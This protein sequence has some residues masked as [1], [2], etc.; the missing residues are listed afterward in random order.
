MTNQAGAVDADND[1]RF[2]IAVAWQMALVAVKLAVADAGQRC[3]VDMPENDGSS[4][5][6]QGGQGAPAKQ[7]AQGREDA[8]LPHNSRV[9]PS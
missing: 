2:A 5:Q 7:A 9:S 6:K 4:E 3:G 8:C 1:H